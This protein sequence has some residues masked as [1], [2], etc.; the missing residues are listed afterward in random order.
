MRLFLRTTL[1]ALIGALTASASAGS[2][3]ES[4]SRFA[5]ER[6]TLRRDHAPARFGAV[7]HLRRAQSRFGLKSA[8]A[9]AATCNPDALFLDGFE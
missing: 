4:P 7:A 8:Q 1:A 3:A 2:P 6:A 9:P 5:L